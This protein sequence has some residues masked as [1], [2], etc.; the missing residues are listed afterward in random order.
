LR[1]APTGWKYFGNLLDAGR[2]TV[3]GGLP[4]HHRIMY[5]RKTGQWAVDVAEHSAG[6]KIGD[7]LTDHWAT[8]GRHYYSRHILK[9]SR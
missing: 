6:A 7:I 3:C 5:G 8:Y 1:A 2:I 4:A 9:P